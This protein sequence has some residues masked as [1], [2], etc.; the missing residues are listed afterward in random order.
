MLLELGVG[1]NT[2]GI[3]RF[4]FEQ[5]AAENPDI[6]LIRMNRDFYQRQMAGAGRFIGMSEDLMD[7]I[8]DLNIG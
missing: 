4:P 1:Y 6:T 5:M 2:P 8:N 3:I 7:V